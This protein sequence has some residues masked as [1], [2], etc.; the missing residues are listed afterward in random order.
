MRLS[1]LIV[2]AAVLAGCGGQEPAAQKRAAT[3]RQP[4]ERCTHVSR[5]FRACTVFGPVRER[6]AIYR[7]DGS[8]VAGGPRGEHGWWRRVVASPDGRFL[9]GQ[10]SGE[11][12]IQSTY[13]VSSGG[14]RTRA[15]FPR[16]ESHALGWSAD[17]RARVLLPQPVADRN[18]QV[19]FRAGT[20][21]V[22]PVSLDVELE[23]AISPRH[24]C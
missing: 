21:R 1:L 18:Q 13:I 24:G 7:R 10:W 17:G 23:R 4:F 11:C 22:D 19:R 2:V 14:G 12:E 6:S 8:R 20:Y 15:I 3:G 9:L 5:G 16:D